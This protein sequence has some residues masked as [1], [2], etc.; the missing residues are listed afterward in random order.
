MHILLVCNKFP[1]PSRDGGSLA[2]S[3][4]ARGL[5]ETGNRVDLIAMNTSKH[6]Y[7]AHFPDNNIPFLNKVVKVFV[8]NSLSYCNLLYNLMFSSLPYNAERFISDEF[9]NVLSGI[10]RENGYDIVQ[11]EGLYLAPYIKTIRDNSEAL[12]VYRCHNIEHLIW[13]SYL[14]REKNLLK[15]WYIGILYKRIKV[16]EQ[17]FINKYDIITPLTKT[18]LE[19]MNS[20]GNLKPAMVAPFGKFRYEPE[21]D[22]S[23]SGSLCLQY[24]GALD[25]MPN[26]E[27]LGWFVDNVWEKIKKKH[28][29][30][31]F[32]VAGRNAGK[33]M[34]KDLQGKGID[35]R[36]EVESSHD[37]LSE[38]GILL[39][40]LF[41]GSGIRV[42]IIEAMFYG[43]PVVA[44]SLAVS[45]IP[46]ENGKHLLIADN[47]E[48]F[49][50]SVQKLIDD[51]EY[52]IR[53]GLNARK[54][55]Y[56]YYD[57]SVIAGNLSDFYQTML[58]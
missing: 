52:A 32:I 29:G 5:A 53:L 21:I 45:G 35:F 37:Y 11:L 39:V 14:S 49:I 9:K 17:D 19:I 48:A 54:F 2:T 16:F 47:A 36:G 46:A 18:D 34:K 56:K 28:P 58:V 51:P 31:I 55:G 50:K 24:I 41:S 6:Y 1:F 4:L 26:V 44:T 22:Y 7:P 42:R 15:K 38:N 30:L 23:S 13:K 33:D 27:A 12:I 8:N 43:K 57:N 3:N 20:M 25:W 10:L 40:P